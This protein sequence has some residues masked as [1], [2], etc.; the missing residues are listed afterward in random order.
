M[1]SR[2]PPQGASGP[3]LVKYPGQDRGEKLV[4]GVAG[5]KR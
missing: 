5:V 2:I 1:H 4:C 3:A